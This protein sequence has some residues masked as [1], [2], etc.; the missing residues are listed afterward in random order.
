[1]KRVVIIGGGFCGARVAKK[2]QENFSV[3]LVDTKDYFEFTP[4][5]LRVA[6]NPSH[7]SALQ[8][9][10]KQYLG[11][12]K[13]I[14]GK[15]KEVSP[16]YVQVNR[17]KVPYDYLIISNGA[18]YRKF[19]AINAIVATQ[20][21]VL[22]SVSKKLNRAKSI[23][24]IGGGFIGVELAAEICTSLTDKKITLINLSDRLLERSSV[25]ASEYALQ[26]LKERNVSVALGEKVI[27]QKGN[28]LITEKQTKIP[29]EVVFSCTGIAVQAD[30]MKKYFSSSINERGAIIVNDYLQVSGTKHIFCGG[31]ISSFQEEK[32]A[33]AAERHA[34]IIVNNIYSLDRNMKLKKYLSKKRPMLISLGKWQCIF[35]YNRI[36]L[37]GF[38]PAL[39]KWYVEKRT[40]WKYS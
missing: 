10:H 5:V 30:F 17:R 27:E 2:L 12:G 16:K 14:I 23:A 24:I 32:T 37:A 39:M 38:M 20:A 18:Y 22:E 1:M 4:G 9:K 13:L 36:C 29:A 35:D 11:K 26:F 33:Q 21:D 28:E 25:K 6:V 31:D 3:T 34:E 8:I 40:M 15:V 19:G 7:R